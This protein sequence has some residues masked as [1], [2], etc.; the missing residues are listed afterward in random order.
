MRR[1]PPGAVGDAREAPAVKIARM[2]AEESASA[3]TPP[4]AIAIATDALCR[5]IA[6]ACTHAEAAD[7]CAAHLG[8]ADAVRRIQTIIAL[9][10]GAC[11]LVPRRLAQRC[12]LWNQDDDARLLAALLRFGARDWKRIAGFVGGGK[13]A[14]QCS[15]RWSRA[16]NPSLSKRQWTEEEDE[17]L[18]DGVLTH[19]PH[20]WVRVA[21]RVG[22]RSDVQCRYRYDQLRK[23]K[24]LPERAP[25]RRE[26][27]RLLA[28][29]FQGPL[30]AMI[31]PLR[32]RDPH[33][34]PVDDT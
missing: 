4:G 24:R 28:D 1:G 19:G 11:A 6:G 21:R 29:P 27:L 15:Q 10:A 33:P 30:D 34:R 32:P 8:S 7:A 25:R 22:S 5:L 13:T 2:Y 26:P 14:R 3:A 9:G 20:N 12:R 17:E 16:L 18:R 31:P 23:M